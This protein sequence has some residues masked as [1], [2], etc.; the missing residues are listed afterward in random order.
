[1]TALTTEFFPGWDSCVTGWTF[2][3]HPCAA[4]FTKFHPISVFGVAFQ[5]LHGPY[6]PKSSEKQLKAL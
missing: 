2:N 6:A 3:F 4:F 5:A 1:M